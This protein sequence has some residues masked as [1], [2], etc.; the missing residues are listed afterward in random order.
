M[1][2][3]VEVEW[4]VLRWHPKLGAEPRFQDELTEE[5][6]REWLVAAPEDEQVLVKRRERRTTVVVTDWEDA[7]VK[8]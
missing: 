6:V 3:R 7:W 1:T 8:E 4:A 2:E 5:E